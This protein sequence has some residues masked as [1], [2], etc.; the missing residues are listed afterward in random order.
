MQEIE[1]ATIETLPLILASIETKRIGF[2]YGAC[3]GG[4]LVLA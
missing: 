1:A 3:V 2:K 4:R